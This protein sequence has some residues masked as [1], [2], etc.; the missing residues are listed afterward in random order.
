MSHSEPIPDGAPKVRDIVEIPLGKEGQK[1]RFHTF[2]NLDDGQEHLLLS[3]GEPDPEQPLVRVH[4]QCL[5]GDVFGSQRCDCGQQLAEALEVL[6]REGGY[7]LYLQQEGRGIGLYRKLAA[8]LLQDQGFDT[9][10]ANRHL[11]FPDDLREYRSAAAMLQAV[12]VTRVRLITNNLD[13]VEQ[14]ERYGVQVSERISTAVY[15]THFNREYL[16]A[17]MEYAKHCLKI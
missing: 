3:F 10:A 13:K 14:L 17:K 8:Y 9:Y 7:L 16:E 2:D 11:G 5:T 4:S 12:G 15:L 1:V 6:E